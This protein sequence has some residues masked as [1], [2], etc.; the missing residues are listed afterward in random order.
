MK[1][2]CLVLGGGG[3]IGTAVVRRLLLDG[4]KVRVFERL[5]KNSPVEYSS[6]PD[7]EW[8]V[9]DF[10][11]VDD[12]GPALTGVQ[13]V[14]HLISTMLPK[15]SNE[16][17][18][19]DVQTN[20]I[21][22]LQLLS[23]MVDHGVSKIVFASSGGTVY[24]VPICVPIDES[25]RTQPEVSYG[26]AKLAI[27]KYLY[28]YS[29]LHGLRPVILRIANPYG[30]GQRIESAQGAVAAFL[31]HALK[32]EPIEIW[33]DGSVVR[34]YLHITD[35]ASAFSFALGY[36]GS[37]QV[38]NIGAGHGLSLNEIAAEIEDQL[39]YSLHKRYSPGREFDVPINVLDITL[40]RKELGWNPTV[41][42]RDGLRAT[43]EAI[44]RRGHDH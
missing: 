13:A 37:N 27:E 24:G 26:I 34:D 40:A 5:G 17:P 11:C 18:A 14:V 2:T 12:L 44:A 25:H 30:E 23:L 20:V 15:A 9:G 36:S 7:V 6:N 22:S 41:S 29:R 21:A 1:K 10:Q 42:F 32:K 39:G 28:L 33:G 35:V 16:F 31:F 8:V 38:F 43:I 4:W 19:R 3:F